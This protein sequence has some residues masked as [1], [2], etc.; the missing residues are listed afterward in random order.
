MAGVWRDWKEGGG[1]LFIKRTQENMPV[2][3]LLW[4]LWNCG[5]RLLVW[6][7]LFWCSS[8]KEFA[9]TG[10]MFTLRDGSGD[11]GRSDLSCALQ[12]GLLHGKK[13][14]ISPVDRISGQT[15]GTKPNRV[16]RTRM[17]SPLQSGAK[18]RG[19]GQLPWGAPGIGASRTFTPQVIPGSGQRPF[20]DAHEAF[21]A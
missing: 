4:K 12:P 15:G 20:S 3:S 1:K 11:K 19:C 2:H 14:L 9:P 7:R 6:H 8:P 18:M 16:M 17:E 21:C 13:A 5:S 10:Q